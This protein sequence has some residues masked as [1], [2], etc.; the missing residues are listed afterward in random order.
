MYKFSSTDLYAQLMALCESNEAFYYVDH[1]YGDYTYR[2]F[3]YR[4]AS[5]TDFL[6]PGALECRGHT[7][8]LGTV[9]HAVPR[10]VSLPMQKFFNLGE[11]PMTMNPDWSKL[12]RVDDKLDGSLI[13]TV[14]A[15]D[16]EGAFFLKSKASF[17]SKQ[18]IDA[19]KWL[20]SN[21]IKS[22]RMRKGLVSAVMQGWTVN[23]EWL[24]ADNQIVI[25][26]D[27]Q[28][29]VVLNARHMETGEYMS[30]ES[31]ARCFGVDNIV[32]SFPVP[33]NMEQWI[34]DVDAMTG[35]EG[36]VV[37]FSDG[38]W[39]KLKTSAYVSAHGIMSNL[40]VPRRLYELIVSETVDDYHYLFANSTHMV[41]RVEEETARIRG[42]LIEVQNSV[43][44][45]YNENKH[46]DRKS[47]AI[48]A[49]KTLPK[50]MMSLV[51]NLFL[52]KEF[53]YKEYMLSKYDLFKLDV[54]ES[55]R[56]KE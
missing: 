9:P 36:F 28:R 21:G 49:Q 23:M 47:Y 14:E 50:H 7:F 42:I 20:N 45:F 11:N 17:Y 27:E 13:S 15:N 44:T 8:N 51:M 3:T 6:N 2:I 32:Q 41:Q 37:R 48:L 12:V 55:P 26:Y 31:M 18:A 16:Y 46:L 29:L 25:G 24:S 5:Y 56:L 22:E 4:L 40:S 43:E 52:E 38:L 54:Q 53:T 33:E 10:L 39:V 34:T 1:K 30:R 35:I 19:A